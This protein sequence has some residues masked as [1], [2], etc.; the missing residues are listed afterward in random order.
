MGI[1]EIM[2]EALYQQ[3]LV[4]ALRAELR[5]E[6]LK[7]KQLQETIVTQQR[8]MNNMQVELMRLTS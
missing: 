5:V 7:N 1:D 3:K 6:I 8:V 2:D 4:E